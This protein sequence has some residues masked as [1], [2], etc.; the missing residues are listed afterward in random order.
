VLDELPCPVC[1]VPL[2]RY[3][4]PA[5]DGSPEHTLRDCPRCG[6]QFFELAELQRVLAA[7][8]VFRLPGQRPPTPEPRPLP[9]VRYLP[10]PVCQARMN[11][12]HFGG[13]SG[14]IIDRCAQHGVWLDAGELPRI[15]RFVAAGGLEFA[16]E[17]ELARLSQQ[18]RSRPPPSTSALLTNED[19]V[20]VAVDAD[21]LVSLVELLAGLAAGAVALVGKLRH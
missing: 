10:C 14:V 13:A 6:G 8:P 9:P 19:D 16:R 1:A 18:A 21:L 15:L 3:L 5:D 17:R 7:Q 2:E 11:R 20:R 4:V 12:N